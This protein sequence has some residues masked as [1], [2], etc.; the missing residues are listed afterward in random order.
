M[1][2]QRANE[3]S[4][5]TIYSTDTREVGK[6]VTSSSFAA[7]AAAVF[8]FPMS[9]SAALYSFSACLDGLSRP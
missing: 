2:E 3:L 6:A 4:R 9:I 5:S 1:E 8:F 7:F